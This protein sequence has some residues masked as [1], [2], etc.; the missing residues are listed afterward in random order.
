MVRRI[1][2]KDVTA[3]SVYRCVNIS[4]PFINPIETK[5]KYN[6]ILGGYFY[7][8]KM[9]EMYMAHAALDR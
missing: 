2:T 5:E 8:C 7:S 6:H 4:K 9:R 3:L 1:R